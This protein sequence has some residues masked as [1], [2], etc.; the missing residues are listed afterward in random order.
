MTAVEDLLRTREARGLRWGITVRLVA[1][2]LGGLMIP[3]TSTTLEDKVFTTTLLATGAAVSLYAYRLAAREQFLGRAGWMCV[4]FDI[5]TLAT[6]PVSWYQAVGGA[7]VPPSY[8]LKNDYL[9]VCLMLIAANGLT[10]RPL[11]PLVATAA[12]LLVHAGFMLYGYGDPRFVFSFDARSAVLGDTVH[13]G[14]FA[15]RI[16]TIIF[17]GGLFAWLA[18]A[19]HRTVREAV[20]L[21]HANAEARRLQGELV[22]QGRMSALAGLVA[23]LAHEINSPLGVVRSCIQTIKSAAAKVSANPAQPERALSILGE[24]VSTATEAAGRIDSLVHKLRDFAGLDQAEVQDADLETALDRT[25]DLVDPAIKGAVEIRKAYCGAASL[26]CR[27]KEINQVL[28]TVISN[29]FQ[30]ME[31]AGQ[32]RIATARENAGL[33]ISIADTG[34]GM[35]TADLRQLFEIRFAAKD[36]RVGMG[37]GLPM[38]RTIIE[39]HGGTIQAQSQPGQGAT[40]RIQLPT[41]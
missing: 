27:A 13:P 33:V 25:L 41:L 8:L 9:T 34:R 37:L 23:G 16:V 28:F 4:A 12:S 15:W 22:M 2:A 1:I 17:F 6:L 19:G 38:A 21:E 26:R 10:L 36:R 29:A 14:F 18:E 31:G 24:N 40:F 5:F 35:A 3:A 7:A 20:E 32:L 30:A 11:Y 39:A